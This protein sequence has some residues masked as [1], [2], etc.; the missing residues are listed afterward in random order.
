M[1][2]VISVSKP[3]RFPSFKQW[4][5]LPG[6]LTRPEKFTLKTASALLI[7]SLA[8]LIGV[9]VLAHRIE[10]PARGGEYTEALIG[11]PQLINPIYPTINDV[12]RD[13]VTLMFS[14]LLKWDPDQGLIPDLA[15][16]FTVNPEGTTFTFILREDA[17]FHNGDPVLARD[18]LFT[19]NAIQNPVYRSPLLPIFKSVSVVQEND[20]TVSFTLEKPDPSFL[21]QLTIGILPSSAWADILPQHAALAALNLQPIGSGFYQFDSFAKDKKGA[22]RSYTLKAFDHHVGTRAFIDRLTFKFY[23]DVQGATEALMGKFV[24]GVSYVPFENRQETRQNRA[25]MVYSPLVSRETFLAFNQKTS[26]PLKKKGVREAIA[27][28]IDKTH[29]VNE[30]LSEDGLVLSGPLLSGI[31]GF[32]N[33]VTDRGFDPEKAKQLL[34]DATGLQPAEQSAPIALTLTTSDSA[35][36]QNVAQEIKTALEAVGIQMTIVS[37]PQQTFLEDVVTPRNFELLLTTAQFNTDPDPYPFWHSAPKEQAGLN[38]TDYANPDVDKLLEMA[39]AAKTTEERNKAY[40]TF[41]QKITDDI[42]AI[43]LYQSRYGYAVSKKIHQINLSSLRV[44]S[45]RFAR[46]NEWYIKT[47]KALK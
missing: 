6:I 7:A 18:V 42:P 28:A 2:Q 12:D 43:F 33:S 10:I 9:F 15:E 4:K 22:I 19:I 35:E 32:E 14:G 36:M 27:Y 29:L 25:V 17:K 41:A 26:E 47:K 3:R 31:P 13:L 21:N 5:Q 38:V 16:S 8:T 11:E 39:R 34:Q 24:E 44:P 20:H 23:P 45:D 46:V 1:R 37:I 40:Q 30:T